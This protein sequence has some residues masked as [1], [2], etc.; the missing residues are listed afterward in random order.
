MSNIRLL[1]V[2]NEAHRLVGERLSAG[3]CVIDA[4]MGNGNDTLFLTRCVGP[5]GYVYGF[6][7]QEEALEHTRER[8]LRER[9]AVEQIVLNVE[10]HEHMEGIIPTSMHGQVAAIMF[11]LGYLPGGERSL[12]TMTDTTLGALDAAL[13]LLRSGGILTIV[14]YPGH[15]GG[16]EESVAIQCWAVQLQI[17]SYQ[18]TSYQFLN[19]STEPP[20]LIAVYK[21]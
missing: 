19:A 17:S 7:I 21:I 6:D 4:T 9:V 12:I 10:S 20:Y 18:V 1:S 5:T 13:R 15:P 8:L 11:N 2:L 16:D 3:D 14:I